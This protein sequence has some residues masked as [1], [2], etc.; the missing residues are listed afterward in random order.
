ALMG[1]IYAPLSL[2]PVCSNDTAP[3]HLLTLSLHDALPISLPPVLPV[4]RA[5][6]LDLVAVLR[7]LATHLVA[8]GGILGAEFEVHR[9]VL[10]TSPPRSPRQRR[11]VRPMM[12]RRRSRTEGRPRSTSN[13]R[14]AR[15]YA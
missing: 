7:Q 3:T 6:V 14:A 4:D 5:H 9:S 13:P 11:R 10:L 1:R 15:R 8:E 12:A 2:S